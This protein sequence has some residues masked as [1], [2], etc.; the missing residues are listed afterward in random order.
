MAFRDDEEK[1]G[2]VVS[3]EALGEV[4]EKEDDED[5]ALDVPSVSD[6]EDK[7]E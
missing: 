5:D 2:A 3:E 7:W 4:M 1:E 6:D